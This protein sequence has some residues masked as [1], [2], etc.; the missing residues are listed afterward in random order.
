MMPKLFMAGSN[1]NVTLCVDKDFSFEIDE[2]FISKQDFLSIRSIIDG[3]HSNGS[4]I[5]KYN[6]SSGFGSDIFKIEAEYG[7]SA[8]LHLQH[9]LRITNPSAYRPV[10]GMFWLY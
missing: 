2:L 5:R 3:K 6:I 10:C 7:G 8:N 9:F 1:F 4:M